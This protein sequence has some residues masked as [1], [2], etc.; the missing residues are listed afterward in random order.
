MEPLISLP[1]NSRGFALPTVLAI[2][3]AFIVMAA[4]LMQ[5]TRMSLSPLIQNHQRV[6]A[7]YSAEAGL[8]WGL[9]LKKFGKNQAP[10]DSAPELKFRTDSS[11]T[12]PEV[13]VDDSGSF[14]KIH[15][16]A[17]YRGEKVHITAQFGRA[18]DPLLFSGALNW[19]NDAPVQPFGQSRVEGAVFLKTPTPEVPSSPWPAGLSISTYGKEFAEN[20]FR[21]QES[22]LVAA[23]AEENGESGNGYF[24]ARKQPDFS[25][26]KGRLRYP[27][28][29]V[30]ITGGAFDTVVIRGPGKIFAHGD[31]RVR[32][33]VKLVDV[34]LGSEGKV[35]FEEDVSGQGVQ[36]YGRNG[37]VLMGQCQLELQALSGSDIHVRDKA[38]T[39][40]NSI[41]CVMAGVGS[42][43]KG[44]TV[45]AI[46]IVNEAK[47]SGFLMAIGS[48]S[49]VVI[50]G[51][52]NRIRGVVL[53]EE[54][55]LAGTIE[56]AVAVRNL[57][58]SEKGP[59]LCLG[60]VHI[61]RSALPPT[62][63]Q[64]MALGPQN[65]ANMVF[66]MLSYQVQS[67]PPG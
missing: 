50:G 25:K 19:E 47:A 30:E 28:G 24:E 21:V 18:L 37:V 35:L 53:A 41:L 45:Q 62:F 48:G 12:L 60:K 67:I 33:K 43:K 7:L 36:A 46:R 3:T 55:W 9:Y 64:P 63:L 20:L 23:L 8:A 29:H 15:S 42:A 4:I 14:L 39:V 16:I 34:T 22:D 13:E 40:G 27:L 10:A 51:E 54:A 31:I 38:Q 6:Q 2:L 44:D 5:R 61:L 52:A 65:S 56:G 59:P 1:R 32:G 17:Q 58:C 49:R 11:L 66:K 26:G 57:K